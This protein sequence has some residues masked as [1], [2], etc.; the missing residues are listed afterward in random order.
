ME[1]EILQK[2][3]E[4]NIPQKF[5]DKEKAVVIDAFLQFS[6]NPTSASAGYGI[7]ENYSFIRGNLRERYGI[8][9]I[10]LDNI[11]AF[12]RESFEEMKKANDDVYFWRGAIASYIKE[13]YMETL[14]QWYD[15]L[16]EEL[17]EEEKR[18][19]L[20]LLYALSYAPSIN[21]LCEWFYCFFDKEER[22]LQFN[23]KYLLIR[24]GLGNELFYRSSRGRTE[25]EFKLFCF[26]DALRESFKEKIPLDEKQIE[27][28]FNNLPIGDIKL[29]EKCSKKVFP[30]CKNRIGRITQ[31]APLI[32]ESSKSYFGISPF[33]LDKIKEL[34][35]A[36]KQNLTKEL[37][38]KFSGTL[39]SFTE[40]N[41]PFVELKNVF[42]V[43]GAYFWQIR[44]VWTPEK[45]PIEV[46][47]LLSPYV[48]PVI[49]D[50]NILDE[51]RE[52][53]SSDLN[54][55]FLLEE[56]L[57]PVA[58]ALSRVSW[59][60][61]L[62]FLFEK[63]SQKFCIVE[64]G[65]LSEEASLAVDSFLSRFFPL[66][67]RHIQIGRTYP[68]YLRDY[69]ENLRFLNQFPRLVQARNKMLKVEP[70]IREAIRTKLMEKLG[71]NWKEIISGKMPDLVKKCE[72]VIQR[73]RDREEAKDFLDGATL[74][75]LIMIVREFSKV[76]NLNINLVM[77]FL[78]IYNQ[79]RNTL[80]HPLKEPQKDLDEK[81]FGNLMRALEYIEDNIC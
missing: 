32:V 7:E 30:V 17:N 33:A 34:I 81:D 51:I 69:M 41:Y 2:I 1:K 25:S 56:T 70:K 54:L 61:Y 53:Y 65:S 39:N 44:Y 66:L 3:F 77:G 37:R 23:L 50:Y 48:F 63:K 64:I 40:E 18:Q 78:D 45:T 67:E 5:S 36:K 71:S 31:T 55:I 11:E 60:K 20:F 79:Y 35:Y 49:S 29:L 27:D 12:L 8:K 13:K 24:W 9:R 62:V 4:I 26:L 68:I 80:E 73:R 43:E 72:G 38:E 58:D 15:S 46:T 57:P 21:D 59:P 75:Q 19:F 14:L 47:I 28:F 74:G 42:E 16:Y 52:K 6:Q 76:F 22:L 10:S